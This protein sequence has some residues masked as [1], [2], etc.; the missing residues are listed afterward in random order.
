[1]S[2]DGRISMQPLTI[3]IFSKE[4]YSQ[5]RQNVLTG[6]EFNKEKLKVK[7]LVY[8]RKTNKSRNQRPSNDVEYQL[9]VRIS[10]AY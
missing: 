2:L 1:M 5:E 10:G 4:Q 6:S 9:I 8:T 7:C 3:Y